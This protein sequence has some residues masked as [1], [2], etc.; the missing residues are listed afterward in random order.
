M[1]LTVKIKLGPDADTRTLLGEALAEANRSCNW[2]SAWA[3]ENKVFNKF[4][5]Q[6]GCYKE[7]SA[8]FPQL[9]SNAWICC[10][11]K[12]AD[13]YKLDKRARREFRLD[14]S[15]PFNCHVLRWET[16]LVAI[17]LLRQRVR[18]PIVVGE[19]QGKLFKARD[20]ESELLYA[21]G[22]YYLAATCEVEE[23]APIASEDVLGVD[24]GIA[25][26][27]T[28]SDGNRHSGA[29][30]KSV[31]HRHKRLRARLQRKGTRAARRRLKRLSGK[32]ARFAR[33]ENHRI[34]K[35]IVALAE[36][37]RRAIALENLEGI[38]KRV[39]V[40]RKQ[41]GT[42]HS[43]AFAQLRTFIEYKA[44][45]RGVTVLIV[46]P[47][48]TSRTCS[49]CGY[50]EKANRQSQEKFRCCSCN[51]QEH[52]DINAARNLRELGRGIVMCPREK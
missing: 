42:L 46:D 50:C 38:R 44:K 22:E 51:H 34:S 25:N 3:F 40:R 14:G 48:N 33:Q 47:R 15:V 7:V 19:P 16:G 43:W 12:V 31:R 6:R 30:T 32:E 35:E 1:Q 20:G 49:A 27:A 10:I 52:A 37:T 29:Q 45:L 5:I 9:T 23:Q 28:D 8:L 18:I 41:R 39:T 11:R 36:G 13:A 21:N 26:I 24:L 2:I 17:T 4:A